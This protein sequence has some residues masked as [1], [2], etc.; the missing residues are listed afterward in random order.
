MINGLQNA[1]KPDVT[2]SNN[3]RRFAI[4]ISRGNRNSEIHSYI[5]ISTCL[6][7]RPQIAGSV[8]AELF[9]GTGHRL[10]ASDIGLNVRRLLE[11]SRNG[12]EAKRWDRMEES[13]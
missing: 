5:L 4:V 3:V 12:E 13:E 11:I 1:K 9:K 2:W 6:Y 7:S 8:R 10:R